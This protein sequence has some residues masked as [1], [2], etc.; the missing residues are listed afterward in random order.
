MR[1]GA[2]RRRCPP[3]AL[4]R[5]ASPRAAASARMGPTLVAPCTVSP[6]AQPLHLAPLHLPPLHPQEGVACFY[7][8]ACPRPAARRCLI[9]PHGRAQ[10]SQASRIACLQ[11]ARVRRH[12]S[13][14]PGMDHVPADRSPPHPATPPGLPRPQATLPTGRSAARRSAARRPAARPRAARR[15]RPRRACLGA[16]RRRPW[17]RRAS[18]P[19]WTPTTR[20]RAA[21]ARCEGARGSGL[22]LGVGFGGRGVP[23]GQGREACVRG[24][25]HTDARAPPR[26]P[27]RRTSCQAAPAPASAS[28]SRGARARAHAQACAGRARGGRL[29]RGAVHGLC[30]GALR[31]PGPSRRWHSRA[32]APGSTQVRGAASA[33]RPPP[34]AQSRPAPQAAAAA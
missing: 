6:A 21:R 16:S 30:V 31:C 17:R 5:L 13:W 29:G 15:S 34:H 4:G 12:T 19:R 10:P 18:P 26:A 9:A 32:G 1:S 3:P 28:V 22:G 14:V 24:G 27:P 2:G 7:L 11:A 20:S 33:A 8:G 25:A 23:P